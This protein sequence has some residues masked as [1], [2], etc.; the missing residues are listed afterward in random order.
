MLKR[1]SLEN[2]KGFTLLELVVVVVILSLLALIV[3]P[4][5][6]GYKAR[7][8]TKRIQAEMES[9]YTAT[10]SAVDEVK[11]PG[12]M[13]TQGNKPNE[14]LFNRIV[15]FTDINSN[16]LNNYEFVIVDDKLTLLYEEEGEI[17]VYNGVLGQQF[18]VSLSVPEYVP[19]TE[20]YNNVPEE[21]VVPNPVAKF[22]VQFL[23]EGSL[24]TSEH[25][26]SGGNATPPV[27]PDKEGCVFLGWD[28]S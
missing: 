18:K 3:I 25:V 23:D 9:V 27:V 1:E 5:L 6:T 28:K 22:L 24:I 20:Y 7:A 15:N 26:L 4:N 2:K 14:T 8:N 10:K 19:V 21:E 13:F 11:S 12:S 16:K 17:Y